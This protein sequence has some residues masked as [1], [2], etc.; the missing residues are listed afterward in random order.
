MFFN[1]DMAQPAPF[2]PWPSRFQGNAGTPLPNLPPL[3]GGP[4]DHTPARV[5]DPNEDPEETDWFVSEKLWEDVRAGPGWVGQKIL[6]LRSYELVGHWKYQGIDA[7]LKSLKDVMVKQVLAYRQDGLIPESQC[8]LAFA[9]SGSQHIVKMYR[10]L[11]KG[12]GYGT[13]YRPDMEDKEVHWIYMEFCAGGDLIDYLKKHIQPNFSLF[14]KLELWEIFHC[15]SR[16]LFTMHQGNEDTSDNAQ[17]W[18]QPDLVHFDIKPQNVLRG[19]P[20]RDS[21]HRNR[22]V[23]KMADFG[24]AKWVIPPEQQD[25]DY[26]EEW[27]GRGIPDWLFPVRKTPRNKTI[28]IIALRQEKSNHGFILPST[29]YIT[30]KQGMYFKSA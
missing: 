22:H 3:P 10:R 13:G 11:Y 5:V 19:G 6:G 7:D 25:Q 15:L 12:T 9:N 14:S 16:S 2:P 23:Y 26:I 1:F 30:E 20:I 29:T 18:N 8:L 4:E 24:L 21:E 28:I 27:E 17:R